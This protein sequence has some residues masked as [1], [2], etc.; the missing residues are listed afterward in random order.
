ML[1]RLSGDAAIIYVCAGDGLCPPTASLLRKLGTRPPAAGIRGWHR[2]HP[3]EFFRCAKKLDYLRLREVAHA[4]PAAGIRGWRK[5]HPCEFFRCAKKL[6]ILLCARSRTPCLRQGFGDGVNATPASFFAALKNSLFYCARGRAHP[7]CGRDWKGRRSRFR[8]NVEE[9]RRKPE[10][11]KARFL[12]GEPVEPSKKPPLFLK[13]YST[14][15]LCSRIF[16]RASFAFMTISP[17]SVN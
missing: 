11:W 4:L 14:F 7:A 8:N 2:C 9:C 17:T 10:P 3:C 12:V 5:R 13:F 6:V 15:L 16:S 1:E